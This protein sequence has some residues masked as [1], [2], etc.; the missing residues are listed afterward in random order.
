MYDYVMS[1]LDILWSESFR[2]LHWYRS[3]ENYTSASEVALN[4]MG[5]IEPYQTAAMHKK[6]TKNHMYR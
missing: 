5:E 3:N 1:I 6:Q 4:G 2:M